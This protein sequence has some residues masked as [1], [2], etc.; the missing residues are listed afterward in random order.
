MQ[1]RKRDSIL[2]IQKEIGRGWLFVTQ[3]AYSS[4]SRKVVEHVVQLRVHGPGV[5]PLAHQLE[6]KAMK[7]LIFR[8]QK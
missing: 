8:N 6:G 3:V 4:E 1:G 7:P 5:I 2:W